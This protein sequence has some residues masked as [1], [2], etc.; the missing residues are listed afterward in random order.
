MGIIQDRLA[1]LS[2][3]VAVKG[4]CRVA[5][6][7]NI[8][9]QGL[10]TVD[11][12]VLAVD[13]RVLVKDQTDATE[14][15]IYYVDTGYWTRAA[16]F[17]RNDDIQNGTRIVVT[18]G[19]SGSGA[20]EVSYSGTLSLNSTDVALGKAQDNP[21]NNARAL[22]A[23]GSADEV[24]INAALGGLDVNGGGS[25]ILA[26]N[27]YVVAGPIVMPES[28][29]LGIS[30]GGSVIRN[31][32]GTAIESIRTYTHWAYHSFYENLLIQSADDDPG[33]ESRVGIGFDIKESYYGTIRDMVIRY[34]DIGTRLKG[35]YPWWFE[36][37]RYEYC[38]IGITWQKYA[39]NSGSLNGGAIDKVIFDHCDVGIHSVE[40]GSSNHVKNS[41]FLDN[42][43]GFKI[44]DT[45]I[46][47][48]VKDSYFER[49]VD[50]AIDAQGSLS[51]PGYGLVISGN[52]FTGIGAE[53]NAEHGAAP[54][55]AIT[56]LR[57][58]LGAK[59]CDNVIS[60]Q[61]RTS[62][63]LSMDG[64]NTEAIWSNVTAFDGLYDGGSNPDYLQPVDISQLRISL[65][66]G[67][68]LFCDDE[69]RIAVPNLLTN[70]DTNS[71]SQTNAI[72]QELRLKNYD[73]QDLWVERYTATRSASTP[74]NTKFFDVAISE[75]GYYTF[76]VLLA[77]PNEDVIGLRL[78]EGVGFTGE[79]RSV[80]TLSTDLRIYYISR[81]YQAGDTARL[82]IQMGNNDLAA[83][84]TIVDVAPLAFKKA[85]PLMGKLRAEVAQ[86]RR[87]R[88]SVTTA[89]RPTNDLYAGLRFD[90]DS[91]LGIPIWWDGAG[92]IDATGTSV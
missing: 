5:T 65:T 69:P 83:Y 75:D 82:A 32:N 55:I 59:F 64:A 6:T 19:T 71:W 47:F 50:Y 10:Q 2:S 27:D 51:F 39:S 38:D 30:G 53:A 40:I 26:G 80:I 70:F 48:S 62:V 46:A 84:S 77:S 4:P 76:P 17:N 21:L 87:L 16:D 42:R 11:G 20:Y 28:L 49:P 29:Q 23:R 7:A 56:R 31:P 15:G 57:G 58:M 89:R 67:A 8:T 88:Q 86:I 92:W 44:G 1:G 37:V 9:L 54:T 18:G 61:D 68:R 90:L 3:S 25:V 13:D 41:M 72:T 36:R 43:V 34:Q 45:S 85:G 24:P 12:V 14:N 79:V 74:S 52:F 91:T 35:V 60:L 66:N 81:E 78:T 63:I 73:G 33:A 22:A